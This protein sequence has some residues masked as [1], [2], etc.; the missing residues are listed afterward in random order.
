MKQQ[1]FSTTAWEDRVFA[2]LA[3]HPDTARVLDA[4][5][6]QPH[7]RH[8]IDGLWRIRAE[9]RTVEVPFAVYVADPKTHEVGFEVA[10]FH[11]AD[12]LAG[13]ARSERVLLAFVCSP[14]SHAMLTIPGHVL[15]DFL[16][17]R[18]GEFERTSVR[19]SL[20][21]VKGVELSERVRVPVEVLGRLEHV[22]VSTPESW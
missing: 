2:L 15:R 21:D 16:S 13:A 1:D 18:A 5:N 12:R 4:R 11:G 20:R 14:H 6:L 3:S 9:E 17:K 7:E 19:V 8:G 22:T 10:R